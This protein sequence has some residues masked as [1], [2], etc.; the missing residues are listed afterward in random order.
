MKR[1][2]QNGIK[3]HHGA[4][5]ASSSVQESTA[6][7]ENWVFISGLLARITQG[8]IEIE[9]SYAILC[10]CS[11][12]LYFLS[13]PPAAA[14]LASW[15]WRFKPERLKV[16]P[17]EAVKQNTKSLGEHIPA[18]IMSE[19]L[20]MPQKRIVSYTKNDLISLIMYLIIWLDIL[21]LSRHIDM[22]SVWE[23]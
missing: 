15:T 1:V 6:K 17:G 10:T 22:S 2:Y 20:F 21:D 8:E 7:E 9:R 19:A 4:S 18:K 5:G 3:F 16:L 14:V 13:P 12:T 11:Y 23:L